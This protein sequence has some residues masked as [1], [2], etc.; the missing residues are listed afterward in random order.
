MFYIIFDN[1][2]GVIL[3]NI[4]L[5]LHKGGGLGGTLVPPLKIEK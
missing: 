2:Y 5:K 1:I 3:S 4:F